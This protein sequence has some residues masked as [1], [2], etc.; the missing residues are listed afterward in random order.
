MALQKVKDTMR[1]TTALD[2]TK[3]ANDSITLA[4]MASGTDGQVI[5]YS[6]AGDPVAIGPGAV[7]EVLTSA[8]ANLPQTFAE[9]GGGMHTQIGS[10]V[11]AS[12]Q[13]TV[14]L[15]SRFD[16]T[17]KSYLIQVRSAV[18]SDAQNMMINVLLSGVAQSGN[19]RWHHRRGVSTTDTS[20]G[21][22]SNSSNYLG[23]NEYGCGNAS[24]DSWNM[25]IRIYNPS[26]TSLYTLFDWNGVSFRSGQ[27]HMGWISG[28]AV[29]TV[30]TAVT[31][32]RFYGNSGNMAA[33]QYKVYG[34]A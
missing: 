2:A 21:E 5:T 7:G 1:T 25:D 19:Y 8:G 3:L 30:T 31:G 29:W 28:A 12:G 34:I 26:S 24:T 23:L 16:S 18:G 13:T 32:I 27:N 4:H 20:Y 11:T 33:G 14:D 22:S 10:T 9:A 6:A 17:Y 15:T